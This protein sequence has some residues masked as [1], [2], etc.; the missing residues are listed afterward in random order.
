[1]SYSER[2]PDPILILTRREIAELMSFGEY[3][4]AV[5]QAFRFHE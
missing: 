5:E 2:T 1:M 4:T 3:V